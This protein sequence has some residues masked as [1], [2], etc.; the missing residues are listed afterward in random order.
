MRDLKDASKSL[1]WLVN[2]PSMQTTPEALTNQIVMAGD[3]AR[4]HDRETIMEAARTLAQAT[5]DIQE[6]VARASEASLQNRRLRQVGLGTVSAGVM[7]GLL[8]AVGALHLVPEH[9]ATWILG[10]DRWK[11]GQRLMASANSESW[12]EFEYAASLPEHN[13]QAILARKAE[14][15]RKKLSQQCRIV[16][17]PTTGA[18]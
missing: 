2:R 13:R 18:N 10:L 12:S 4:K 6:H 11:A 7:V 5:R 16:V 14:S 8:V 3:Q 17:A 9:G 1:T 15:D